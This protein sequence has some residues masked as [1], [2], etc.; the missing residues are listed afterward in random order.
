MLLEA[1]FDHARAS[2]LHK[3]ELEVFTGNAA[4]I[5]LYAR[6]G[7]EVEGVRRE[8]YVRRDGSRRDVMVMARLVA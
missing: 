2:E 5:S 4:A 6:N 7:F 1:A 3:V 8:H